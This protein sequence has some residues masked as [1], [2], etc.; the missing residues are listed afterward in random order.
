MKALL[1]LLVLMV[2]FSAFGEVCVRN[3]GWFVAKGELH[4][5]DKQG[6]ILDSRITGNL[7]ANEE[8]CL[9]PR[10][11]SDNVDVVF[12]AHAIA[13]LYC[14]VI[15]IPAIRV[16]EEVIYFRVSGTSLDV[17]CEEIKP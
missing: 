5:I 12:R 14:P 13:G 3:V 7:A 4:V 15:R 11:L 2:S 10:H 17:K 6:R 8:A 16:R 1:S 9:L